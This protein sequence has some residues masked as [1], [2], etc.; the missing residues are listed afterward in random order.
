MFF[1]TNDGVSLAYQ[2]TGGT[3]TTLIFGAGFSGTQLEWQEQ[4]EFFSQ[5][6]YRVVTMD[7]RSHGQSTRTSKNLRISR[8]AADLEE[9]ITYL[10]LDQVVLIGHSMGASI[11]WAYLSLFGETKVQAVV[12]VDESPQLLNTPDWP[13]GLFDISWENLPLLGPTIMHHKMTALPVAADLKKQLIEQKKLHP[14]NEDL[15]YPLLVNHLCQDWRGSLYDVTLP[16]LFMVGGQSPLWPVGYQ[17][18]IKPLLNSDSAIVVVPTSGHLIHLEC[19]AIFNEE[20]VKFLQLK[21][22]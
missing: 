9:L 3:G 2:D 16:Q 4:V 22:L 15:V 21:K 1:K 5:Q 10:G 17:E 12:A 7:W 14:F 13:N 20:V 19:P 6:G 8:L 18:A 11:I